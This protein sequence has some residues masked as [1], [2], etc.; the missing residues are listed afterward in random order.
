MDEG[1]VDCMESTE[2]GLEAVK[3]R[4]DNEV[5]GNG[6]LEQQ[7]KGKECLKGRGELRY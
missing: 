4:S 6:G 1:G 7:G 2:L 5:D 3:R